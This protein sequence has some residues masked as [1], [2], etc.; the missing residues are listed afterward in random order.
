[1]H[2]RLRYAY[3]TLI[4]IGCKFHKEVVYRV[5]SHTVV[6]HLV[7]E[8]WRKRKSRIARKGDDVAA[9]H[10]L[11]AFCLHTL[12]MAIGCGVAISVVEHD[13]YARGR[14]LALDL[15]DNAIGSGKYASAL[16]YHIIDTLMRLQCAVEWVHQRTVGGGQKGE[17]VVGYGLDRWNVVALCAHLGKSLIESGIAL[18]ECACLALEI[19]ERG[20]ENILHLAIALFE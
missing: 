20:L 4:L 12:Q 16:G 19:V 9:L 13:G 18:L 10:S 17:L 6:A 2:T 7:V 3:N 5:Y 1:M 15:L 8:V 14:V 11:T